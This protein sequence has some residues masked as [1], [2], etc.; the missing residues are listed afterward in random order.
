LQAN[1]WGIRSEDELTRIGCRLLFYLKFLTLYCCICN[2]SAFNLICPVARQ[3]TRPCLTRD[4]CCL[5]YCEFPGKIDHGQILLVGVTGKF[6]Y[7]HY[8]S[9]ISH[10]E[11][12][13]YHCSKEFQRI[14]PVAATCVN[15][16]WSPPGLPTCVPK[17]HPPVVY[18]FRGRRSA[19]K[20]LKKFRREDSLSQAQNFATQ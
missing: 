19:R 16:Q 11:K 5:D 20:P 3:K 18:I 12:I 17:Q 14:G 4:F 8:M 10:N 7:R 13:E 6:E 2:Y 1:H 9:R 15:G